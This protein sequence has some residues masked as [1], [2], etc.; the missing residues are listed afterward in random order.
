VVFVFVDGE[1]VLLVTGVTDGVMVVFVLVVGDVPMRATGVTDGG[2]RLRGRRRGDAF[3][4]VTDGA[5]ADVPKLM[6]GGAM[7]VL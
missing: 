3:A 2:L 1:M 7:V 4:G 5:I 6:K